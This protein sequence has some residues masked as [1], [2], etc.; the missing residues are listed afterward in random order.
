MFFSPPQSFCLTFSNPIPPRVSKTQ[1]L[2]PQAFETSPVV[3]HTSVQQLSGSRC[4]FLHFVTAGRDVWEEYTRISLQSHSV[5]LYCQLWLKIC[6]F[7]IRRK[8]SR[9][10]LI[11]QSL[12]FQPFPLVCLSEEICKNCSMDFQ[13]YEIDQFLHFHQF[14]RALVDVYKHGE[15]WKQCIL[16]Y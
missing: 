9:Q 7:K 16:V 1:G 13:L 8:L 4:K 12:C 15:L 2:S 14:L 5:G 11:P 6:E 10:I 3:C